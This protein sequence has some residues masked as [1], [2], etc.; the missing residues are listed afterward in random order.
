MW[1]PDTTLA[2]AVDD[3]GTK[4]AIEDWT[5]RAIEAGIKHVGFVT[6]ESEWA[7][8]ATEEYSESVKT[9]G[10]KE[11]MTTAFFRDVESAKNW[12]RNMSRNQ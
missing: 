2:V 3:E 1:L 4:W 11:G 5:P 10:E 6:S 7:N 8:M 9:Y 12:F